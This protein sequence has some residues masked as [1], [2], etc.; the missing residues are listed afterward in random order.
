MT[1]Y[2]MYTGETQDWCVYKMNKIYFMSSTSE[3]VKPMF[4]TIT[5]QNPEQNNP[6]S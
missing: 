5:L 4:E 3:T 6:E 2:L 1:I